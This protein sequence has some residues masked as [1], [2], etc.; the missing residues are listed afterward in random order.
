M[1]TLHF[2]DQNESSFEDE[3]IIMELC[4]LSSSTRQ[5]DEDDDVFILKEFERNR[6]PN[7]RQM[8][9]LNDAL[10][11]HSTSGLEPYLSF[12]TVLFQFNWL[13]VV[14]H[15]INTAD[16]QN[17]IFIKEHISLT[18]SPIFNFSFT[19]NVFRTMC[20]NKNR[21]AIDHKNLLGRPWTEKSVPEKKTF[22]GI[23]ID[24][25]TFRSLTVEGYRREGSMVKT[26]AIT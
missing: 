23:C 11:P 13:V 22:I 4:A 18:S 24:M 5:S 21:Y 7:Q 16:K 9:S 20:A 25:S 1:D 19:P 12:R 6:Q 10:Q 15:R 2:K 17:L 8:Y 26:Y 3:N 14:P